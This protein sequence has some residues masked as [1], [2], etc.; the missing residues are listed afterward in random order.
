MGF[1]ADMRTVTERL[2]TRGNTAIIIDAISQT[3]MA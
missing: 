2:K 3:S 1:D